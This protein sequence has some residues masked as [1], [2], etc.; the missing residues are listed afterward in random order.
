VAGRIRPGLDDALEAERLHALLDGLALHAAM[1]PEQ[2]SPQRIVAVLVGHL[3]SLDD[4]AR[5][6]SD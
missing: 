6:P 5:R 1:R 2:M 3:D 4:H